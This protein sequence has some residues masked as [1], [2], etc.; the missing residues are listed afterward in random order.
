MRSRI[1][2]A[3]VAPQRGLTHDRRILA[4][5]EVGAKRSGTVAQIRSPHLNDRQQL[6]AAIAALE[7]QRG[8]VGDAVTDAALAPMRERLAGIREHEQSL[9]QVTVLFMDV[10][11]STALSHRLDPEEI[12]AIID[13]ALQRLTVIVNDHLGRVRQYAC[14]SLLAVFGAM[15]IREP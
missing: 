1:A 11:G 3:M 13:G 4:F 8:L 15:H 6:E 10:V 7:A 12:H 14:D 9:R 5:T 2:T